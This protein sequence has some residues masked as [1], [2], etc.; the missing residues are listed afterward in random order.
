MNQNRYYYL[1]SPSVLRDLIKCVVKHHGHVLM[2]YIWELTQ[3]QILLQE[4]NICIE[5]FNIYYLGLSILQNVIFN[6]FTRYNSHLDSQQTIILLQRLSTYLKISLWKLKKSYLNIWKISKLELNL[7]HERR[8]LI[9]PQNSVELV[10]YFY[11]LYL[12]TFNSSVVIVG[13]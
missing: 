13:L 12:G 8:Y 9:V 2:S 7:F 4:Y 3:F 11:I 6:R 10:I 1:P 5:K